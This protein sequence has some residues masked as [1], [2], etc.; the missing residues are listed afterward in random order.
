MQAATSPSRSTEI[1]TLNEILF[2]AVLFLFLIVVC[3]WP[4]LTWRIH[5]FSTWMPDAAHS[6]PIRQN[7]IT[8]YLKP[9]FGK[10]FVTLPWLWCSLLAATVVTGLFTPKK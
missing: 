2:F 6:Y 9:W 5:H 4:A 7:G 1:I 3:V 8:V 10:F